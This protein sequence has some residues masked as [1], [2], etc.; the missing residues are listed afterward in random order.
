MS[1]LGEAPNIHSARVTR[2]PFRQVYVIIEKIGWES[3]KP[4]CKNDLILLIGESAMHQ[5]I[6]FAAN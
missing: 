3:G 4:N 5:L 2:P 1:S 6:K